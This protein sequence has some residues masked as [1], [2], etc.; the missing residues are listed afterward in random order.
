M[1]EII[2]EK[3]FMEQQLGVN[4]LV[5]DIYVLVK[6][7]K[8]KEKTK[9]GIIILEG[10]AKS[11]ERAY[12][13]GLIVGMGDQCF[14]PDRFGEN[15]TYTNIKV[16]DWIYYSSYEREKI[17]VIDH[18]C[19]MIKCDRIYMTIPEEDLNKL[20]PELDRYQ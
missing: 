5:H 13:I 17:P 11:E 8:F 4:L 16:G 6:S 18:S 10:T 14:H 12:N 15:S 3:S 20:I 2:D 19:Y 9:N 7:V 1:T